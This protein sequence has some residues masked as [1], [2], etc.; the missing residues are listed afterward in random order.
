MRLPT[1]SVTLFIYLLHD[2]QS[3]EKTTVSICYT[4]LSKFYSVELYM[5]LFIKS[6]VR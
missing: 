1:R 3:H 2:G 5:Y 4:P 6:K